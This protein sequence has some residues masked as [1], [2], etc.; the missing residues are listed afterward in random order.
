MT[1]RLALCLVLAGGWLGAPRPAAAQ[2]ATAFDVVDGKQAFQRI[3]ANCHGPD[4]DLVAGVDLGHGNFR[5][6]YSDEQ[7]GTIILQGIPNTPMPPNPTMSEEQ[8]RQIV[9]YLRSL[10]LSEEVGLQG[11]PTRGQVLF[12]GR[13]DCLTCHRVAGRGSGLGPE[14]TGVGQLRTSAEL[15]ESLLAP[16]ARVLPNHRFYRVVTAQGERVSGRL[17]NHDAFSVQLLD[18]AERLRSFTKAEL[19]EHGFVAPDMPALQ[20]AE[21]SEQDVA[22]LVAYLASLRGNTP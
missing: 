16:A 18:T 4:G 10:A 17:L 20:A 11:E 1:P 6:P 5:Q 14:L 9:A 2:H 21:Y 19:R 13:G 3:C 12:E 7:L 22:D 15:Q 8:A